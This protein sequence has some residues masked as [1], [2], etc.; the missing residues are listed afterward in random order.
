M[1][2]ALFLFPMQYLSSKLFNTTMAHA[3]WANLYLYLDYHNVLDSGRNRLRDMA[4]FLKHIQERCPPRT[5]RTIISHGGQWRNEQT[6]R[7]LCQAGV[8][9]LVDQIVFTRE[10]TSAHYSFAGERSYHW[11]EWQH[12]VFPQPVT[13]TFVNYIVFSGGKDEYIRRGHEGRYNDAILLVDDKATTLR[14]VCEPHVSAMAPWTMAPRLNGIEMN[15]WNGVFRTTRGDR[16]EHCSTL[17]ELK[18]LITTWCENGGMLH[19][20]KTQPKRRRDNDAE[21]A[22]RG[23]KA[24]RR[25]S[26]RAT[27]IRNDV[28]RENDATLRSHLATLRLRLPLPSRTEVVNAYAEMLTMPINAEQERRINEAFEFIWNKISNSPA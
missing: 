2:S 7:E 14:A 18:D 3:L 24:P 15:P 17:N 20:P 25:N 1:C 6:I 19:C 22:G 28:S 11:Y 21:D 4:N 26:S 27:D 5:Y 23:S 16:Y 10:R 12:G 8:V 9:N 13:H